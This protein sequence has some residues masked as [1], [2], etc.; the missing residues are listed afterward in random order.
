M[1]LSNFPKNFPLMSKVQ[2]DFGQPFCMEIFMIGAWCLW[3]Q[4]NYVIFERKPP[5]LAAWKA[6][7]KALFMDHLCRIK[8][9][10]HP[11]IK[12]LFSWLF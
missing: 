6:A 4:R 12:S 2:L 5:R 10:L 9:N 11:S 7:F 8:S 3:N 1:Y